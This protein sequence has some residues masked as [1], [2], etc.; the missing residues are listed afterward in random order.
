MKDPVVDP[1]IPKQKM[2]KK[3]RDK[4]NKKKRETWDVYPVTK[5]I[6]SKKIYDRKR[7]E[8]EE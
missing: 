6:P 7:K 5:V 1:F 8:V 3:A 2:S 4:L